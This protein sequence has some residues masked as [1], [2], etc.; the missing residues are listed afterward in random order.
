MRKPL[1]PRKALQSPKALAP[2]PVPPESL[3][4]KFPP[5][6]HGHMVRH[7][8]YP[9]TYTPVLQAGRQKL[10]FLGLDFKKPPKLPKLRA[11]IPKT[12]NPKP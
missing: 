10:G 3:S 2:S 4:L 7:S 1:S 9:T 12:L 11:L 8:R 5:E 6:G